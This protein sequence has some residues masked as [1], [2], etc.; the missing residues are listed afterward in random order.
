MNKK[1]LIAFGLIGVTLL[2]SFGLPRPQYVSPNIL[3]TLHIPMEFAGWK[4]KDISKELNRQET[5]SFISNIFARIYRNA[6]G[7]ELL[8]LILDAGNFHNPKVC[9]GAS[10]YINTDLPDTALNTPNKQFSAT[11]VFLK[12]GQTNLVIL[13]WLCIN[14]KLVSWTGQK[15]QELFYSL[16]NKQKTGLMVRID[17]PISKEEGKAQAAQFAHQFVKDL[18][19]QLSPQELEYIFGK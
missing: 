17:V 8:L 6:Q 11:T 5:Y 9:Y 19:Q 16:L 7:Q 18:S 4:A 14:K 13:Y 15:M 10:G 1:H 12:K 3:P 2:V